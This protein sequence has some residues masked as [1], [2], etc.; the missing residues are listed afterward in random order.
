M[1][2]INKMNTQ[3]I[4]NLAV[5]S[6]TKAVEESSFFSTYINHNDKEMSWDGT[7]DVFNEE[8]GKKKNL[9]GR[10]PVQVKGTEQDD[11]SKKILLSSCS[12]FTMPCPHAFFRES[13]A[14][15]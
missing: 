12:R 7:I 2:N 15:I 9:R 1:K 10:F 5:C 4:E 13:L 8:K 3:T 11:L 14:E 6:V